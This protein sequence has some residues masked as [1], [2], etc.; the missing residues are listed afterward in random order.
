MPD[1]ILILDFGSQVT[2]LI[3]RRVREKGVYCEIFP[4]NCGMER[5]QEY[6]PKGLILSGGPAS[7][8]SKT[9]PKP[10]A[11]IWTMGLPILGIC[12]GQQIMCDQLGGK[13][14]GSETQEFGRAEL[15]IA[16]DMAL[17]KDVWREGQTD[18]VWMSH[19]DHVDQ[20]PSGFEIYATSAGAPCAVIANL[21]KNFYAV[22]FHP[23]VMHT[24]RGGDLLANFVHQICGC[25]GDWTMAHFKQQALDAIRKKVG[26]GR[27]IC[28]L[29][30]GVDGEGA[31]AGARQSQNL[32]DRNAK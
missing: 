16:K 5:I 21:E 19:G 18:I 1:R 11:E 32:A 20:L 29:S 25:A 17:F 15:S 13:V 12:Y 28:G 27:V 2:Q 10:A 8:L 4:Y 7:A 30:D 24:P 9:A 14:S 22:Q 6:N 3:A 23:E 26:N 31:D